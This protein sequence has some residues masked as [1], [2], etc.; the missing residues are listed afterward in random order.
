MRGAVP[1]LPN[2]PSWRGAQFKKHGNIFTFA[3]SNV[4]G[5]LY[6]IW[7]M[8]HAELMKANKGCQD[9]HTSETPKRNSTGLLSWC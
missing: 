9:L 5:L 3:L 1:L 7:E 8:K 2:K 4:V 6:V